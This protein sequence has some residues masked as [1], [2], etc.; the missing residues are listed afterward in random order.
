MFDSI[1]N[2]SINL[3]SFIICMVTALLLGL[4]IAIY[5]QKTCKTSK[6]FAITLSILPALVTIVILMVN[7]NLGTS[8]AVLGAFSLIRFRSVPGNSK[9]I[10]DIFFAM[11]IGLAVGTGYISFAIIT[12]IIIILFTYFLHIINFGEKN[13]N[14][15]ILKIVIPEDLDYTA[16]FDDILDSDLNE[17]HL[18]Q[19]KTINMGSLF[20][21]TY[22]VVISKD[23]NEK[24]F[25]DKIRCRNGNL[26]VSLTHPILN[27]GL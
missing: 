27:E 12:T 4:F 1:I 9:E 16:V 23:K 21:L 7:G 14:H 13:E 11:A 6:N 24:E 20:E 17:Y 15:K 2:G 10:A 5:H 25:I 22:T 26:K 8:I 18:E 3:E 19:V